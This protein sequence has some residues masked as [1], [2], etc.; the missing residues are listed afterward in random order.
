MALILS[1]ATGNFNAGATWVG[2]V[3]PTTGDEA[4]ASTGHT[5]TITA[6][7][8]CTELSNAGTGTYVLNSGVTL[9]AN[10]TN[11]TTTA[12]VNCLSFSAVSPATATIVGNVTG[13]AASNGSAIA[14]TGAIL[15]SSSGTL[16][17]QGSVVGGTN[18]ICIGA[19]NSSTGTI[20]ITGNVTGGTGNQCYGI[21][22]SST[23]TIST[24]G[25]VAGGSGASATGAINPAAGTL[26]ITGN[27]SGGTVVTAL[28]VSNTSNGTVTITST[29]IAG[30]VAIAVSNS[31]G[32]TINVTGNVTG[33]TAATIYGV[34]NVGVG[35]IN[36]TGNVTGGTVVATSH[37]LNNT[38]TGIVAIV[39]ICTGGAAGAAGS[40]NAAGGTITTTRAK[41]NGFGIGSV[42][43]A[44]GVGIASAQSSITK[45]EEVEFGALGM[46]PVS[47][48]CYITPL[49]TN[50]AI[51][52]KYPGGT[53]T[54]TLVDATASA[55]MPAITDVRFGTSYASGALTGVAYIPAAGSVALGVP[56]DATTG[57]ATLTAADVRA[58][59]GM[60]S[61]NLDTQLAAIPTAVTNA[62]AVWDELMS[63]HTTAGTY[64]GRIVRAINANNELQLTGSHHAAAVVHD[65]Q[66]AVIQSVAFA[67]SAVTLF[68]GAM[69]TELT[70]ELTEITEVHAIHGL[71]IANA[72]T[73]TP[74]SRTSGAI[75]Q[76]ITGDGTTNTVVTR[77]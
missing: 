69:R 2:G 29:T 57:T 36:V 56:V 50:V 41:G 62:N 21:Y 31:V 26:T 7:V 54:K 20:S 22:N 63:S 44:A 9:T 67:T 32:G 35:T 23:G 33:G 73:V 19:F 40:N 11:K 6:N 65:F 17:V 71:D 5:I 47:G 27:V 43:T 24:S 25:N 77:V 34:N 37:G 74:T 52:T 59:I 12:N 38:S 42:A 75:T 58:A 8:T 53:G 48:P 60:A 51:F 1:A 4:R 14:G 13:G 45:I 66:A 10:V 49:T 46:S 72:L 68:T 15:N 61:A 30:T 39:G 64:G 70:P 28:G 76:A 3:V 55:G 16:L 18:V